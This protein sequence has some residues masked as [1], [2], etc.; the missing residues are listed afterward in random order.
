MK[1]YGGVDVQI[2]IFLTPALV[3]VERSAS[4]TGSFTP[5]EIAPGTHWIRDWVDHRAGLDDVEK[6]KFLTLSGL[7]L[8][9]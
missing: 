7:E 5:G 3:G 1:V 9:P 6:K 4:R 2:H 8:C